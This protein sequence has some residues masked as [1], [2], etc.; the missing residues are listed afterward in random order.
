MD[1]ES[2]NDIIVVGEDVTTEFS[3]IPLTMEFEEPEIVNHLTVNNEP[4]EMEP[5]LQQEPI[6]ELAVPPAVSTAATTVTAIRLGSGADDNPTT[7]ASDVEEEN[8]DRRA[9]RTRSRGRRSRRGRGRHSRGR[10]SRSRR[11]RRSRSRSDYDDFYVQIADDEI[12]AAPAGSS[13]GSRKTARGRGGKAT[14]SNHGRGKA[15]R[16]TRH[17]RNSSSG[18]RRGRKTTECM[19]AR[20]MWSERLRPLSLLRNKKSKTK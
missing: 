2:T 15:I 6:A 12:S 11:S 10:R 16:G 4:V 3:T 7:A 17:G 13:R 1:G 8:T 19:N 20:T 18:S 14:Q 9:R 5:E